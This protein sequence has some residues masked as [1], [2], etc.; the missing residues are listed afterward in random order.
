MPVAGVRPATSKGVAGFVRGGETSWEKMNRAPLNTWSRIARALHR[1]SARK[2]SEAG[3]ALVEFALVLPVLL[4]L[5]LGIMD[6]GKAI[7]YWLDENHLASTGARWAAVNKNPGPGGT[8]QQSIQQGGDTAALRTANV[9]ISFPNG[10]TVGQPVTVT[11]RYNYTW[12]P[13]LSSQVGLT[14]IPI[15]ATATMRLEA[16]PSNY[17]AGD[18]GTGACT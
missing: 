18:G 7:N 12:L 9:C 17:A 15:K 3:Q 1:R 6:I 11:M 5:L 4:V 13:F 14:T 2:D 10:A 16:I 8:L